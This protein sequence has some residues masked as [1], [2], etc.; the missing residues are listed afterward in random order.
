LPRSGAPPGRPSADQGIAVENYP[1]LNQIWADDS[2]NEFE[3]IEG[4]PALTAIGWRSADR[5]VAV[6][7]TSLVGIR[8][9]APQG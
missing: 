9:P 6:G 3:G 7:S 4:A 1:G 5:C 2:I 8:K